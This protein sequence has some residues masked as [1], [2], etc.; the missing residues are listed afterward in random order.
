MMVPF[1]LGAQGPTI[2]SGELDQVSGRITLLGES[3]DLTHAT[4]LH[5]SSAHHSLYAGGATGDEADPGVIV[6]FSVSE[7]GE[8]SRQEAVSSGGANPCHIAIASEP[9]H[10]VASN[11]TGGTVALVQLGPRGELTKQA[12]YAEHVGSSIHPTRQQEP[13]PHGAAFSPD[14]RFVY[15]CD[16]GTDQ[17]VRY[18]VA[19]STSVDPERAGHNSHAGTSLELSG[20]VSVAPGSGPR[21]LAFS[22]DGRG[23]LVNELS[24]TVMVYDYDGGELRLTQ[25]IT[26]LPSGFSGEST[27]AEIQ[28]HPNGRFLYASNRGSDS[29]A[30][31]TRD[32]ASGLLGSPQWIDVQGSAP[33]HFTIDSTGRWMVVALQ[34][35]SEVRSF[36]IDEKTGMGRPGS[37]FSAPEPTCVEFLA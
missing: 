16:L 10:L 24:N 9:G 33:R 22:R 26:T 4:W 28:F 8:L 21:H 14:G 7:A 35:S 31:Y 23:Y 3:A 11:Y 6:R 37:V 17:I 32:E 29:I 27:A 13:H 30:V 18:V 5:Y 19:G 34:N 25:T 20:S 12:F 2:Y 36:A 1:Y 15:V